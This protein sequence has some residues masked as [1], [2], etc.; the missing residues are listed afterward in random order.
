MNF[1]EFEPITTPD[2]SPRPSKN[3]R[4]VKRSV[5]NWEKAR[6][7]QLM[8]RCLNF[9]RASV[10]INMVN[11]QYRKLEDKKISD[12]KK[13]TAKVNKYKFLF[14]L[15]VCFINLYLAFSIPFRLAFFDDYRVNK[16]YIHDLILDGILLL[17][18]LI[19]VNTARKPDSY[20]YNL[21]KHK[22]IQHFMSLGF[23]TDILSIIP[24]YMLNNHWYW[25]KTTRIIRVN[26]IFAWILSTKIPKIIM[27][28]VNHSR[29]ETILTIFHMLQFSNYILITCHCIAC[30]WFIIP[31]NLSVNN[32]F[33]WLGDGWEVYSITDNY[34]RSLYWT[35]VTFSS[36][37]YG[38]ITGKTTEEYIYSMFVEFLGIMCFAFFMGSLTNS[39]TNYYSTKE[40]V[41]YRENELNRWLIWIEDQI[42]DRDAQKEIDEKITKY[43]Q[44]KWLC[45]P[46]SLNQGEDYLM[47]LPY[48]L[49]C[50]L[51]KSL[52]GPRISL[53][54]SFFK[55]FPKHVRYL[56]SGQLSS[57]SFPAKV[58]IIK[59]GSKNNKIYFIN[60]GSIAVGSIDTGYSLMLGSSSFFGED[61]AI[62][63]DLSLSS[64][65]T[66]TE[67]CLYNIE[68]PM[69]K[70]NLLKNKT[71]I[72][73]FA[74][75]AFKRAKYFEDVNNFRNSRKEYVNNDE[76]RDF[77]SE[78]N[79]DRSFDME[80]EDEFWERAQ[81]LKEFFIKKESVAAVIE[82]KV[83][84]EV[85]KASEKL[86]KEVK[87]LQKKY[88]LEIKKAFKCIEQVKQNIS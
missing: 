11:E 75:L 24:M 17:H 27:K 36:V 48:T 14:D 40:K 38:D 58:E 73:P 1:K 16:L 13:E 30:L 20:L 50:R 63:E 77:C 39:L 10:Y 65:V 80:T 18:I 7:I 85:R 52:F 81:A 22:F 8:F 55:F 64:F 86:D 84:D 23:Y 9:A 53:F 26:S 21:T 87:D 35:T 29:Y 31:N 37:G 78:Y 66:R 68:Y 3:H 74:K 62:F 70:K 83:A 71:D 4:W 61:S 76:V 49:S 60:A 44:Q 79:F 43:F 47:M 82:K 45:D 19:K 51:N 2:P 12:L 46:N 72:L 6:K 69:L 15:L 32:D 88:E 33:T 28:K 34:M 5:E 42:L 54:K 57:C 59:Q 41:E 25:L 56:I 67:T